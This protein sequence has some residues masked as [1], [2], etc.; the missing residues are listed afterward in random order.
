M[1]A[2]EVNIG[3]SILGAVNVDRVLH[4]PR[5]LAGAYITPGPE[6]GVAIAKV[7]T[8]QLAVLTMIALKIAKE[9]DT[10]YQYPR[11]RNL[12]AVESPC[13]T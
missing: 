9:K 1:V 7:F 12:L 8:A 4:R 3:P 10:I 13:H 11:A 6:I 2:I 5:I